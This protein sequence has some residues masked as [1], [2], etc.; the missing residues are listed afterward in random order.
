MYKVILRRLERGKWVNHSFGQLEHMSS[1]HAT[2]EEANDKADALNMKLAQT[3]ADGLGI[4]EF[5]PCE[6]QEYYA[7]FPVDNVN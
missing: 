7:V 5:D 3:Y 2:I 4:D 1:Y 6:L